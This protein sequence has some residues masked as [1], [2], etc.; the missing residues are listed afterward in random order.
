MDRK[1]LRRWLNGD[2]TLRRLARSLAEVYVVVLVYAWFFSDGIIFPRHEST[3]SDRPDII[4]IATRDGG[5]ISALY[6]PN[7]NAT[8]TILH[9][10]GNY[11]DLGEIRPEL[12]LLRRAGFSVF[13]YDYRG[14]GT[15]EGR[16][17]ERT[18]YLDAEAAYGYLVHE[19]H[20]PSDRI[21]SHGRSVGA[22]LA[23]HVAAERDVAG[24]IMESPFVTAFRV[25]TVIPLAPFDKFRNIDVIRRVRCPIL[26][27]HGKADTT[28]PFWHGQKLFDAAPDPKQCLWVDGAG[29]DDLSMVA[30]SRYWDSIRQFAA[31]I[32]SHTAQQ[33]N[34]PPAS[35]TP[36][37]EGN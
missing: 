22:A 32:K 27:M 24:L 31:L 15:S 16:A 6:L 20:V 25:K 37:G 2:F 4:K 11:E 21:I 34:P 17:T 8:F 19:L 1:S 30:G 3:Y 35:R 14:Y 5:R 36:P 10:H 9:S 13:A 7:T 29:H 18:T 33:G 23:L 26:V 12:D 28:I